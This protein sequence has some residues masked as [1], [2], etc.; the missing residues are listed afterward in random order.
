MAVMVVMAAVAAIIDVKIEKE[1]SQSI[2]CSTQGGSS[3]LLE[4]Y[5]LLDKDNTLDN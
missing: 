5:N 1:L 4:K 2:V 3:F